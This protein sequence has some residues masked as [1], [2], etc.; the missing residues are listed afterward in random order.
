MLRLSIRVLT[1][2]LA[3]A[4]VSYVASI[5]VKAPSAGNSIV[6]LLPVQEVKFK[7]RINDANEDV[8]GIHASYGRFQCKGQDWIVL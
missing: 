3:T 4:I 7:Y 1:R 5:A 2:L 8:D 6:Q